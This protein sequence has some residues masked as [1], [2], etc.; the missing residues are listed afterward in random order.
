MRTTI[1]SCFVNLNDELNKTVEW[2]FEKGKFLFELDANIYFF[3][4]KGSY[5]QLYKLRSDLGFK[6]KTQ[7]IACPLS[8]FPLYIHKKKIIENR[9]GNPLYSNSR[10]TTDYFILVSSK[11][12]MMKISIDENYF[13]SD[14]FI[15]IDFG[16][17]GQKHTK[18]GM[19]EKMLPNIRDKFS[20]CYIHYRHPSFIKNYS[21]FYKFGH[22]GIAGGVLSGNK[23]HIIKVYELFQQK[24]IEI[25]EKGYG[26]AEEQILVEIEGDHPELFEI[27]NG[28]YSS[29]ISNYLN[30]TE[31]VD[32]ILRNFIINTRNSGK[33]NYSYNACKQ[34]RKSIELDLIKLND[35][36]KLIYYDEYF[37][38]A[39]YVNR[40]D[41]FYVLNQ[42]KEDMKS[43]EFCIAF[44]SNINH[45]ITN[46]DFISMLLPTKKNIKIIDIKLPEDMLSKLLSHYQVFIYNDDDI[47]ENFLLINNPIIRKKNMIKELDYEFII[48]K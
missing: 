21:E 17:N 36:Q 9:K 35:Y 45:Y 20:C 37:I 11:L 25:V 19:I 22:C 26:H 34:I 10:N 40:Q 39:W 3:T 27:Y 2:Y 28:D 32:C 29:I 18:K 7:M 41:C 43:K 23:D 33:N 13:H 31:D 8:S 30:I 24:F 46:F 38:S 12:E 5:D 48:S 16:I 14:H 1:V 42:L 4:D 47:G 44:E 15:W 6:D